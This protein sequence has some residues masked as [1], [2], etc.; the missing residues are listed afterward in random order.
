M[1]LQCDN[2]FKPFEPL[3]GVVK[4]FCSASCRQSWHLAER[5]R[6]MELLRKSNAAKLRP[7]FPASTQT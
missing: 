6:A 5:K 4:R 1:S 2:C 7:D 3:Q